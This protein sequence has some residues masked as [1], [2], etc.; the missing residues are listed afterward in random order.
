MNFLNNYNNNRR[1]EEPSKKA[2][3]S[4]R[5]QYEKNLLPSLKI[6]VNKDKI[7]SNKG[8]LEI[9]NQNKIKKKNNSQFHY[10]FQ[11]N[12]KPYSGNPLKFHNKKEL[13]NIVSGNK[14]Y[15]ERDIF[16]AN[17]YL[18]GYNGK[19]KAIFRKNINSN[20]NEIYNKYLIYPSHNNSIKNKKELNHIKKIINNKNIQKNII[21]NNIN[22]N[23]III[24]Q[25]DKNLI[26]F[27]NPPLINSNDNLNNRLR[28][29]NKNINS[30]KIAIIANNK[31]NNENIKSNIDIIN[32]NSED[33][34]KAIIS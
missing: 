27:S 8:Y 12:H 11:K 2:K 24:N 10:P 17:P 21:N 31:S 29:Q 34:K 18:L 6:A 25:N 30:N 19:K 20:I 15:P 9:I 16:T 28:A 7:H 5:V 32:N 13:N 22:K 4:N 1:I 26:S 3:S 33:V 14:Y 23:E